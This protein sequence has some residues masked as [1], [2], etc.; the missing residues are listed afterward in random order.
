MDGP[1]SVW[2]K[3]QH[4]D[5]MASTI[6]AYEFFDFST[7]YEN[8]TLLVVLLKIPLLVLVVQVPNF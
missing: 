4:A 1:P 5:H 3:V 8:N 6:I 7:I 2:E